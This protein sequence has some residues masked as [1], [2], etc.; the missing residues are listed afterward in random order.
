MAFLSEMKQVRL[1]Q[2]VLGI[3]DARRS[4]RTHMVPSS[5]VPGSGALGSG[6]R[7]SNMSGLGG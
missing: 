4:S 5:R 2:L 3:T 6:V 7:E 1:A